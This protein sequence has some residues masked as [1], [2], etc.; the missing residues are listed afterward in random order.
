MAHYGVEVTPAMERLSDAML[1]AWTAFAH[2]GDPSVP[3][4]SWPQYTL[5][6]RATLI[7]EQ[8]IRIVA[9]PDRKKR[10]RLLSAQE[11]P[12]QDSSPGTLSE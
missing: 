6:D 8:D 10:T 9:D 3:G 7:F 4:L 2:H 5:E 1:Y 11:N 12:P